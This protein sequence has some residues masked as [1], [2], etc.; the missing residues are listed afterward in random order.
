MSG[1]KYTEE[2]HW[3]HLEDD[4]LVTVGITEH[5]QNQLGD[6]VFVQ[7]PEVGQRLDKGQEAV[8]IESVKAASGIILPLVGE[9]VEI[10]TAVVDEPGL[11]N[12]DPLEKGWL[13][14]L[15]AG[16]LS[17]LDELMDPVAYQAY[18]G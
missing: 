14:K 7:L 3:L 8:V 4:G 9:V 13:L 1:I 5:A 15:R 16:D 17:P 12:D 10:N 2:H 18:A 11:I 6:I